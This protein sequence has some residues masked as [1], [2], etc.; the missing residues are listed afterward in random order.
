MVAIVHID[1]LHTWEGSLEL[2]SLRPKTSLG[3]IVNPC[4][5]NNSNIINKFS[6]QTKL[7]RLGQQ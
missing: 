1:G 7:E 2:M 3:S 4:L 6:S 5:N